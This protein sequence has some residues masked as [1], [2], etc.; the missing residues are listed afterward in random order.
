MTAHCHHLLCCNKTKTE[1]NDGSVAFYTITKK[2]L[3]CSK[4]KTEGNG[5]NVVITFCAATKK[6]EKATTVLPPLPFLL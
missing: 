3:C 6:K 1:E 2:I 5:S 4:T